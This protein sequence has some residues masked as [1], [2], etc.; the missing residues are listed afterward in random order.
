MIIKEK[1]AKKREFFGVSID[2]LVMSKRSM[3]VRMNYKTG[4]NVPIHNHPNEQTG[5]IISGKIRIKFSNYDEILMPGD[6][7]SIPK[8]IKH[9]IDVLEDSK[10][11]DFF[12]PPRQDYL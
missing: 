8:G 5:Y 3:I 7:Y 10:V 11:L 4:D 2:I 9:S 6:S 12:S 1:D